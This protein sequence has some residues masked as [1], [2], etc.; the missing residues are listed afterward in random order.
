MEYTGILFEK[1]EGLATITLNRID[2]AN[3]FGKAMNEEVLHALVDAAHDTSV[4][5]ILLKANGKIFSA[6]GDLAEMKSLIDEKRPQDMAEI[7]KGVMD[8]SFAMKKTLKPVIIMGDGA[9]AGA[10]FN[11]ALAADFCLVTPRTK[12]IQAFINV[13]LIPDAGGLFLLSRAVGMNRAIHLAMTGDAV[14]AEEAKQYGFVYK[15][16]EKE[17]LED[18]TKELVDKLL[19]SPKGSLAGMK[20]LLWEAQFSEW[21]DYAKAELAMQKELSMTEDFAEGVAAFLEKRSPNFK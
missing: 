15:I 6:G 20:K 14:T 13:G 8:I 19:K 1:A 21:E 7:A 17:A 12:F 11:M 2:R 16:A 9:M 4:H 3:G 18:V 10:A 5:V